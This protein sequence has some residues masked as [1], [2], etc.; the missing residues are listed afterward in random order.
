MLNC[1]IRV[2]YSLVW[3]V[4]SEIGGPIT[5]AEMKKPSEGGFCI[6][7]I[8]GEIDLTTLTKRNSVDFSVISSVLAIQLI[9]KIIKIFGVVIGKFFTMQIFSYEIETKLQGPFNKSGLQSAG[10]CC[11]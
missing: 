11:Y 10:L 1:K 9:C 5:Y 6:T 7:G 3:N 8:S 4:G 2:R